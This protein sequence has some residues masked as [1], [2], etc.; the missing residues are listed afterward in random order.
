MAD[1][2][3]GQLRPLTSLSSCDPKLVWRGGKGLPITSPVGGG[4]EISVVCSL[5]SFYQETKQPAA[6][7]PFVCSSKL[8]V[9]GYFAMSSCARP[10]LITQHLTVHLC[11]CMWKQY[12]FYSVY[13]M[14]SFWVAF[15]FEVPKRLNSLWLCVLLFLYSCLDSSCGYTILVNIFY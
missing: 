13:E 2:S 14:V 8:C 1:C 15:S 7:T 11:F 5:I 4:P 10:T 3:Y 6:F 9:L 12:L